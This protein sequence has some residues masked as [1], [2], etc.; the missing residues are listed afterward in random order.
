MRR[1]GNVCRNGF[2]RTMRDPTLVTAQIIYSSEKKERIVDI[3]KIH[4]RINAN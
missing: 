3:F 4:S 2:S 1:A